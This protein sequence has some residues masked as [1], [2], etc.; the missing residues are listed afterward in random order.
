MVAVLLSFDMAGA[1]LNCCCLGA[2]SVY[3]IQLCTSMPLGK[4]HE[5]TDMPHALLAE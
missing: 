5:Y 2:S 4:M 1:A 3:T